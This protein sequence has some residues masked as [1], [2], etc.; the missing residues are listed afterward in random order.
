M[1]EQVAGRQGARL[2]DVQDVASELSQIAEGFASFLA[3]HGCGI[4]SDQLPFLIA[5][6]EDMAHR[7]RRAYDMCES[8]ETGEAA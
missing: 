8:I 2:T 6:A 3:F 1:A 4:A 5:F 7:A